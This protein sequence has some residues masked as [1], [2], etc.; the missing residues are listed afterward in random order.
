MEHGYTIKSK[1]EYTPLHWLEKATAHLLLAQGAGGQAL[2]NL[3]QQTRPTQPICVLY[4][5]ETA[6]DVAYASK[7]KALLGAD[8][9]VFTAKQPLQTA[10]QQM[11]PEMYMGTRIYVAGA[12]D[13]IWLVTAEMKPFGMVPADI[14]QEQIGTLARPVYC[15]HCKAV[16]H[17]V[18][19]NVVAC[20]GCGKML[21]VRDHFS[22][23]MGAYMGLMA[24]AESPGELPEIEEIY[25]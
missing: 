10:L 11:L 18:T 9:H 21:F 8:C 25:R 5:Q 24:D 22:R 14:M 19:T 12:E 3:L 6:A 4:L 2:L 16:T 23:N 15:V 13:F 17:H 20:V 7:M 1:P